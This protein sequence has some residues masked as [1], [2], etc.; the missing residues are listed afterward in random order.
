MNK[1]QIICPIAAMAIAAVV[2]LKLISASVNRDS[3]RQQVYQIGRELITTTNSARVDRLGHGLEQR[4][5]DFLGSPSGVAA[6]KSGDEPS[7]IGNGQATSRLFLTNSSGQH[8]GIRLRRESTSGQFHVLG[9]WNV[10][11]G[12]PTSAR[13]K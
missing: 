8:L 11:K 7:P 3:N 10:A 4:L 13:L 12:E 6:V 2:V 1:W 9:F 5:S